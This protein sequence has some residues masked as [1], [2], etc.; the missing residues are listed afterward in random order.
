ML[1]HAMLCLILRDE[2]GRGR[3]GVLY[4]YVYVCRY[5]YV[6]TCGMSVEYVV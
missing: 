4:F 2:K 5:V 1:Y 6:C 3:W